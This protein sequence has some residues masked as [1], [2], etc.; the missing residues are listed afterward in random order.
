[1][2]DVEFFHALCFTPRFGVVLARGGGSC[3]HF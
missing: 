3:K 1:M 2:A